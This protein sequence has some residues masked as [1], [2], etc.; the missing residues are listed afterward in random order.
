MTFINK[1]GLW[2]LFLLVPAVAAGCAPLQAL[3]TV[4][5]SE[6]GFIAT[7]DVPYGAD[8]R[9]R[10]DIYQPSS[11]AKTGR[12]AVLFFYGGSWRS[13]DRTHYRFVGQALAQ[14][15]IVTVIPDYR[16]YP[17]V[18]FPAFVEDAAAALA[19]LH[20]NADDYGIDPAKVT[21]VGHSAGAHTAAML[22]IDDRF[23]RT[24]GL[25]REH[26]AGVVGL[27]G[28]YGFDPLAYRSTRP[29]FAEVDDVNTARP[30]ALVTSGVTNGS[31]LPPFTLLHGADDTT[32]MLRNSEQLADALRATGTN[33]RLKVYDGVGHYRI[34]L[35]FFPPLADWAPVIEDVV[36][37]VNGDASG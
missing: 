25:R 3:D 12:P 13:G 7:R 2:S 24:A 37:A 35:A 28:P 31:A 19:W 10:L 15:G 8:T 6:D 23:V 17:D 14:R 9:H 1:I 33:V 4:L 18:R 34:L 30:V 27:A 11:G 26:I 29:I 22:A 5:A 21:V 32:V 16:L 20:A 36:V